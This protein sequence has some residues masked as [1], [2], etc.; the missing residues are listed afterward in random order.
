MLTIKPHEMTK[1]MADKLEAMIMADSIRVQIKEKMVRQQEMEDDWADY[2]KGLK[3]V[4]H[5]FAMSF[6][7]SDE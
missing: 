3:A 7:S 6:K 5:E 1:A 4:D 2:Y